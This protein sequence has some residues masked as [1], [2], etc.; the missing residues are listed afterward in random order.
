MRKIES[1]IIGCILGVGPI[2]FCLIMIFF[3]AKTAGV[4]TDTTGPYLALAVLIIGLIIDVIFLKRWVRNAYQF[5]NKILAAI[6]IF[7]SIVALGMCMGVPLL[8]FGVGI[9]AGVYIARRLYYTNAEQELRKA[10]IKK[11]AL[12]SAV[13]MMA[14]CCLTG[15]W[16]L[17]G[18]M[19]GYRFE[20][21]V[22][23]FTF[24]APLLVA[25]I[26]AGG[27]FLS[28][29]QYCLTRITARL[30]IKMWK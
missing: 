13:V 19:I 16:A 1:L 3:I 18:G 26:L 25:T 15:T 10:S 21:P 22:L 6:Y 4:L 30:A 29:L 2:L 17:I 23:S 27:L 20:N 5:N 12:F 14:M 7:Y 9:L 8:N 24:T 28:V 11:T